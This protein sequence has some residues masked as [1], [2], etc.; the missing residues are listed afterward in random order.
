VKLTPPRAIGDRTAKYRT[1]RPWYREVA[2]KPAARAIK[3]ADGRNQPR[4]SGRDQ[5]EAFVPFVRPGGTVM[6]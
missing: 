2:P 1:K 5:R 3:I 4:K 6:L